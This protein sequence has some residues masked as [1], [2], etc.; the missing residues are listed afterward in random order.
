MIILAFLLVVFAFYALLY[1]PKPRRRQGG[2]N[3]GS[4]YSSMIGAES[5][6]SWSHGG[7]FGH[8]GGSDGGGHGGFDGH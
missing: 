2:N 6:S 7:S 5:D 3:A 4:R 8:H 1:R